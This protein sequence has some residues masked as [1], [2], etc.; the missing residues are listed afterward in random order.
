MG[1][2]RQ[3][4]EQKVFD[5][6]EYQAYF[7]QDQSEY[8]RKRLRIIKLYHEKMETKKISKKLNV[9]IESI[10]KYVKRYVSGG[11]ELV[12]QKDKRPR[13]GFLTEEQSLE[14]KQVIL[15]KKPFE[16]GLEGNFWTGKL[17]CAY[18]EKT[19]QIIYQSGIYDLLKRLNLTHQKAHADYGNA[20]KEEQIKFINELK[21]SILQANEENSVVKFDEFSICE[22]PSSYYGWAEKNT[23]PQ[24]VTNEKKEK[25]Q[26]GS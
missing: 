6:K 16:M 11:F 21:N 5:Q 15:S 14:F 2:L 18:L 13:E 22:K 24:F 7:H 23:R 25:E 19:Y 3:K 1:N 9:S 8:I 4:F 10:N 20:E 12:C 17:M 26:M